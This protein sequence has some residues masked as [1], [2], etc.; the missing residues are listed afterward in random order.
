M[1][2]QERIAQRAP[3]PPEIGDA[4]ASRERAWDWMRACR[5]TWDGKR[6]QLRIRLSAYNPVW[7]LQL[8]EQ[9]KHVRTQLEAIQNAVEALEEGPER[10]GQTYPSTVEEGLDLVKWA[11]V[12]LAAAVHGRFAGTAQRAPRLRAGQRRYAIERKAASDAVLTI[13][14]AVV[15]S[16]PTAAHVAV[17]AIALGEDRPC[18][19]ATEFGER[20]RRWGRE[21]RRRPARSA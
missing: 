21:R 20:Y 13:A 11:A 4:W 6:F 14:R 5:P 7:D 12:A 8:A 19:D 3:R 18:M 15:G 10:F 9:A 2:A 16:E 1:E 17:V